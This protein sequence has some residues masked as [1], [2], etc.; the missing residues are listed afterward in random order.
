VGFPRIAPPL[1]Q[2]PPGPSKSGQLSPKAGF[3]V[4]CLEDALCGARHTRRGIHPFDR[5]PKTALRGPTDRRRLDF[6]A[7]AQVRWPETLTRLGVD[8]DPMHPRHVTEASSSM[9]EILSIQ[10]QMSFAVRSDDG[11]AVHDIGQ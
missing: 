2:P 3:C 1:R 4:D 5:T 10:T 7:V 8:P 9:A 6:G 11:T